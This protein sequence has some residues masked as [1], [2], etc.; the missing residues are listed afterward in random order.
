VRGGKA[1][2]AIVIGSGATHIER[3]AASELQ[4]YIQAATDARIPIITADQPRARRAKTWV[5]I[6]RAQTNPLVASLVQQ[7]RLS[8]SAKEPGLDGFIIQTA[9]LDGRPVLVLGGSQDR[10]TLYAVYELLECYLGVGFFW[11]GEHIPHRK[12]LS[13]P[14]IELSSRPRFPMREYLQGCVFTYSA[15]WW[16]LEDWKQEVDW[17]AKHK[18]NQIYL[19]EPFAPATPLKRT[20]AAFG[21]GLSPV[22]DAEKARVQF[23]HQV[24]DYAR[25]LGIDT[26][27]P[28]YTGSVPGAFRDA[29]PN[30]HY[31]EVQWLDFPASYI[32]HPDD[33]LFKEV[34]LKFI[35]EYNA[36]F[37]TSHLYVAEPYSETRPGA[38]EQEQKAIKAGFAR[39]VG[40]MIAEADP[41]A[42]WL[43]TTWAFRDKDFW[44]K[45]TVRVFVQAVP[46]NRFL[47]GDLWCEERPLYKELEYLWGRRW[48]FGVLHSFGGNTNLHGDLAD[49]VRRAQEVVQDPAAA[50]CEAFQIMSEVVHY[51][52]LYYDLCTRLAWDPSAV[53]LEAFL[54]DYARRRYGEGCAAEMSRCLKALAGSVYGWN[55][56]I[57]PLYQVRPRT[58]WALE[59]LPQ[60][61]RC[62]PGL[63]EALDIALGCSPALAESPLYRRDLVDMAREYLGL[64][65]GQ[66]FLW[67]L[68]AESGRDAARLEQESDVLLALLDDVE[69]LLASDPACHFAPIVEKAKQ[70][71][72]AG[73]GIERSLREEFTTLGSFAELLDYARRD[74]YELVRYYYR[75]R[76]ERYLA[77]AKQALEE[78]RAG[79]EET[80]INEQARDIA[81]RWIE[82]G[83]PQEPI[84]KYDA[85]ALV[86]EIVQRWPGAE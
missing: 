61:L 54:G 21:V 85:L 72:G 36:L 10:G 56:L 86:K 57:P 68:E 59:G 29:Y 50:R 46:K 76:V 66:H 23:C 60:R 45:D 83:Y 51:N 31:V 37:G 17:A 41:E 4:R 82:E 62:L 30:A 14:R 69:R 15:L 20:M 67:L 75:P 39:A 8:L 28:A 26:I 48:G 42:T 33:P 9:R 84:P 49:L 16:D 22:S 35:R 3:H 79:V 34:G 78:G 13:L 25:S 44:P 1:D 43:C 19:A 64:L 73:A 81:R 27:S 58:D 80:E 55:D 38:T 2:A 40:E 12:D 47:V 52:H 70:V 32:L 65:Y 24:M 71:P 18:I 5:L 11:D 63:G 77:S 6:G 53:D 74:F 7:G